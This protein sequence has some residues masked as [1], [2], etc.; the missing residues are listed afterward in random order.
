MRALAHAI[1]QADE[2][3]F[4]LGCGSDDDQQA[5]RGVF[6][7]GLHMDAVDPEVD[8]AFGREVALGLTDT[9]DQANHIVAKRIIELAKEL[10]AKVGDGMR[11]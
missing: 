9:D 4:A 6:E 1:D 5:L 10:W 8:V 3:L 7:P 2:F 11:G